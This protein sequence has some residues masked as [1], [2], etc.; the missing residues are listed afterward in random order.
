MADVNE[1]LPPTTILAGGHAVFKG[2]ISMESLDTLAAEADAA[3]F[4]TLTGYG[5][6]QNN[7]V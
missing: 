4:I 5:Y 2:Q 3:S 7:P 6:E 1:I